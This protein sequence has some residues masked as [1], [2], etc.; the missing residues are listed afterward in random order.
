[1]LNKHRNRTVILA[2]SIVLWSV[3][4]LAVEPPADTVYRNGYVYTVDA[5]DSTRQALAERDGKIVYVGTNQ[6][7][8][9]FVGAQTRVMD[10][11]GRM[12]MPGLVDGHMHPLSGGLKLMSCSLN[13]EALTVEQFRTRIQGC[14]DRTAD[15]EPDGWLKVESWFQTNMLPPGTQVTSADLDGLN[16]KRPILVRSSFGHT[17]LA[18]TRAMELAQITSSTRRGYSKIR[19]R[20]CFT[21]CCPRPPTPSAW[22]RAKPLLKR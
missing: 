11:Q 8:D 13:Y 15:K 7:A 1:M 18:N 10:L 2:G 3:T 4:A 20:A 22:W 5:Q 9:E 17:T 21:T 12:M 19:P 16:T 14:L 6:G